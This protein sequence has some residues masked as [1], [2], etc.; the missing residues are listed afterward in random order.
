MKLLGQNEL[1]AFTRKHTDARKWIEIWVTDVKGARWRCFQ[2][3]RDRYPMADHIG[4][5]RIIFNVKGNKYRME[6]QLAY[7]TKIVLVKWIGTHAEYDK[8]YT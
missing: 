3:I 1:D 4:D 6:V 5:N 7:N 2:D 8:K